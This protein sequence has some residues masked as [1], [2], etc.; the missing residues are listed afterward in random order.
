VLHT[1][2]RGPAPFYRRH[3]AAAGPGSSGLSKDQRILLNPAARSAGGGARIL[4]DSAGGG[5]GG[6]R[7]AGAESESE[8]D[9]P[10]ESICQ[11]RIIV[12]YNSGIVEIFIILLEY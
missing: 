10:T 12:Q 2:Q 11:P 4:P 8:S 9:L 3:T 6:G 5:G 7:L 1:C